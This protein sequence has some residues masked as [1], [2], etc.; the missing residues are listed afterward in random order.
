MKNLLKYK[1]QL[2]YIVPVHRLVLVFFFLE[3]YKYLF[4]YN[5][6]ICL[7]G[8]RAGEAHQICDWLFCSFTVSLIWWNRHRHPHTDSAYLQTEGIW[9][10]RKPVSLVLVHMAVWK[11]PVKFSS[12]R[13]EAPFNLG[14]TNVQ[15]K[16][17]GNPEAI[18]LHKGADLHNIT[19]NLLK[20][21]LLK[22]ITQ[23]VSRFLRPL[24]HPHYQYFPKNLQKFIQA[25]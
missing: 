20:K 22:P 19:Q 9:G 7:W 13:L 24:Q 14:H 4:L 3:Q 1:F 10:E 15:N 2:L 25:L 17:D 6:H 21:M 16:A 23:F 8:R 5:S 12:W 18:N 11:Q